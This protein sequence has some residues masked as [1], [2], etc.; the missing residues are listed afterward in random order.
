MRHID[1]HK[2]EHDAAWEALAEDERRKVASGKLVNECQSVWGKAKDRLKKVSSGKCW[3]CESRQQRSDN[4]VDHFRPK[5]LYPWLSLELSNFRFSCTFCN[6]LRK[7]PE[8]GETSGKGDHF[9][10]FNDS[11]ASTIAELNAEDFILLD[12]CRGSDPGL[13]DFRA[14]GTSCAKYPQQAKRS[15]RADR[16]IHYYH[17]N[18]PDLRESRRQLAL[19]LTEWIRGA[20]AIYHDGDQGDPKVEQAFSVFIESICRALCESAEFSVF[21]RRIIDGYRDR[22]WIE[23]LLDCA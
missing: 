18:H 20:D 13:L 10:L 6:S 19:Q 7:N 3:Y 23:E 15:T 11:R 12:P 2:I 14:D 17:L 21:A 1:Q 22:P 8:T 4:A 16:S 9:P 5:S